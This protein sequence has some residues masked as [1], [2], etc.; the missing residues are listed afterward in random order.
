M[1]YLLAVLAA[2]LLGAGFVLQQDVAQRAPQ[3][4]FLHLSLAG[5]LL[6]K[7]RW[8]AG[9]ATMAAGQVL[10]AWVIGHIVLSLA[11]PLLATNLLFALVLAG[12]VSKQPLYRSEII[13][14]LMLVVGVTALSVGRNVR[15]PHLSVGQPAY[16]PVAGAVAAVTAYLFA[17]LGRRCSGKL[18]AA[19]TGVSAGVVFGIQD[20]LTRRTVFILDARH[21]SGLLTTWPGYSL[22]AVGIIGLWLMQ[23]AFSAAPLHASLPAITACEPVTGIAIGIVIFGDSVQVSPATIALQLAGFIAL[24]AGVIMVARAPAMSGIR[25]VHAPHLHLHE[26]PAA[27]PSAPPGPGDPDTQTREPDGAVPHDQ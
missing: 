17:H 26:P 24:I 15:S 7:P 5:D 27:S 22:V 13:G 23:S 21:V 25:L 6:R 19:L 20:A 18:R 9:V 1:E 12:P 11:E 4:H 8:L 16:W 10:S 3:S 14:A 2:M